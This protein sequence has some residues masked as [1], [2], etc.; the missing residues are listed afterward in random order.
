MI[1]SIESRVAKKSSEPIQ[2]LHVDDKPSLLEITELHLEKIDDRFSVVSETDPEAAIPMVEDMGIDCIVSDY[3]MPGMNGLELLNRIREDH[4]NLPFILFTGRGSEE[5]ASDAISAGVTDYLQKETSS[6]QYAVLANRIENAVAQH[7][8]ERKIERT[9]EFFSTILDHSSDFVM[10]VDEMG[11]I[12]Y[13]SPAIERVM[14]YTQ[15]EIKG[16]NAFEFTHPE[17]MEAATESL[18]AVINNPTE[19]HSVEFR[20]Q[21]D[22]GSWLWLEVRGRNLLDDSII[23]GVMVNVRDITE[24]KQRESDLEQRTERLEDITRFLS[25]DLNNQLAIISGRINLAKEELKKEHLEAAEQVTHR[26]EEMVEKA[27]MLADDREDALNETTVKLSTVVEACWTSIDQTE[28]TLQI[29]DD[30]TVTADKNRFKRLIENLFWNAVE[31]GGND[32]TLTVGTLDKDTGFFIE[33][34]GPGI[35]AENHDRIFD[36][37][38]T[39]SDSGTGFGLSIV[40]Q[41]AELHGW[42]VTI[43]ESDE[44][45]ARFEFSGIETPSEE[46]PVS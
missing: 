17:D 5:V 21:H 1:I 20:A 13:V 26:I 28:A 15:E 27:M 35:D 19:E 22:D 33:D 40:Q 42:L 24:R 14:G 41:I 16:I 29:E 23:E 45:G 43:E 11:E 12:S 46:P 9:K 18:T 4:P 30:V 34:D 3:N 7:R 36:S 6:D 38:Y 32:V 2:I 10:I 25:H 44:G 8:A 37:E 31:H 39:T